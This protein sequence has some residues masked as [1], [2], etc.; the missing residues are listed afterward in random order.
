MNQ[1]QWLNTLDSCIGF[2]S[3]ILLEGRISDQQL[4][5][6]GDSQPVLMEL[7]QCLYDFLRSKGYKIVVF[8]NRVDG[9]Y[10][11]VSTDGPEMVSEFNRIRKEK[12]IKDNSFTE[13][14]KGIR[15]AL[16][17]AE[18]SVAVIVDCASLLTSD[19]SH[20]ND[21]ELDAFASLLYAMRESTSVPVDAEIHEEFINNLVILLANRAA[22]LPSWLVT[23]NPYLRSILI[24]MP[25]ETEREQLISQYLPYITFR[26]SDNQTDNWQRRMGANSDGLYLLEF[27]HL[28]SEAVSS[29]LSA[30]EIINTLNIYRYGRRDNPWSRLEKQDLLTMGDRLQERVIGQVHAVNTAVDVVRRAACGL[31]GTKAHSDSH[32]KGVLFFAG[33]TGTGKTELAKALAKEIFGDE[34]AM[35]RF[36][37]S[38]YSHDHSDQRLLGAPPGY[39]GYAQGGELT[40]AVKAHPFSLLLFDEIE[41]ASPTIL[42]KFLQLLDDGRLTDSRGE[43]VY[44]NQTLIIFTSNAGVKLEQADANS[45][46]FQNQTD[47]DSVDNND[48][49]DNTAYQIRKIIELFLKP[50]E[51]ERVMTTSISLE[52]SYQKVENTVRNN[53]K[54]YF[55]TQL[56]RPEILNRIGENIVVFDFIRPEYVEPILHKQ[57]GEVVRAMAEQHNI[58][59][60]IPSESPAWEFLRV[61]SADNLAFGGRGIGN[62][63]EK[64]LRNPLANTMLEQDWQENETY[65]ITD[66][67]ET[68]STITLSAERIGG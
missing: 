47:N 55:V 62:I 22:D 57:V 48:E 66:I 61:K 33:P 42:D 19:P 67:V 8:Y 31:S 17:N 44:F 63:V 12:L 27:N 29:S 36:D 16:K 50:Q 32:P 28:L 23:G 15:M 53:L 56:H 35:L 59:L 7:K 37:M 13:A 1:P 65:S 30:D 6:N 18:Q 5:P 45:D 3:G 40:N 41:K 49:A 11:N 60:S 58:T 34:S 46:I 54:D 64:Y 43:T 10:N 4:V 14:A 2:K 25:T 21:T 38:E 9:F 24:P 20:P 68:A 26:S 39:V 51:K 52:D